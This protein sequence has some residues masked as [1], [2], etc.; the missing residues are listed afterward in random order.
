MTDDTDDSNNDRFEQESFA[1]VILG[2]AVMV[3]GP[4]LVSTGLIATLT[5]TPL[6][7]AG[8]TILG[9]LLLAAFLLWTVSRVSIRESPT[10]KGGD[11]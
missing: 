6:R 7:Q 9:S 5:A 10:A 4:A 1:P 8:T 2:I 11:G 3:V